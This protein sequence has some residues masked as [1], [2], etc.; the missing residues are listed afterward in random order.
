MLARVALATCVLAGYSLATGTPTAIAASVTKSGSNVTFS[1]QTGEANSV[2]VTQDATNFIFSDTGA[3]LSAGAGCSSS[4]ANVVCARTSVTLITI[5]LTELDDSVSA[6]ALTVATSLVGGTGVDTLTGGAGAD[7]LNGGTGDDT[8]NG[9]GGND[10]FFQEATS[11][12]ADLLSGGTGVDQVDYMGRSVNLAVTLGDSLANDG[13]SAEQDTVGA[14]VEDAR[15]G[16]GA[17]SLTGSG[18]A[19]QLVGGSGND[20]LKGAGGADTEFG[21]AGNDRFDEE[22][23]ANG[24]D[25]MNGGTGSDTADYSARSAPLTVTVGNVSTGDGA[26]LESDDV[27]SDVE[28]VTGG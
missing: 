9:G 19:N 8:E 13:A 24:G 10:R 5:N 20:T 15:T 1:G 11:N 4:G 26:A 21:D 17:D 16:G 12:G 6:S 7:T 22:S 3:A 18:A 14:D 28:T 23:L 27:K 25:T 2:T